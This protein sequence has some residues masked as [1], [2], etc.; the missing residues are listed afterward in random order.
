VSALWD[1]IFGAAGVSAVTDDQS[2]L[3]ALCDAEA[4]L[5]RSCAANG[6]LEPA[7]A[8]VV[9]EAC[10]LVA[11]DGTQD[12]GESSAADGNPVIPLVHRIKVHAQALG[13]TVACEG[14]HRGATSQD[15][16]DT[17]A[18]LVARAAL[19]VIGTAL[20]E[21]SGACTALVRSHRGTAM[22][23]RTLMQ[24]ALPTTFGALAAGW[25]DGLDL[26][27]T[28]LSAERS[29]L[30]VQLGGATGTLAAWHPHGPAVRASMAADLGLIDP[31][32]VWHTERSR[33]ADL[34]TALGIT[35]GT[36]GKIATDVVLLAQD[37]V[38]EVREGRGG[39]SSAMPHKHNPIAAI[40]AR[41]AAAQAPG[42]VGTLLAS[43]VG[44][45]QRGAGA[46]HAEWQPLV[47]LLRATGG[48]ACRVAESLSGLQVLPEAMSRNLRLIDTTAQPAVGATEIADTYL[49]RHP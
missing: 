19:E 39:G 36:L 32:T 46:W 45:L 14:V 10:A 34:A 16:L 9:V 22:P 8:A 2:W 30:A 24:Q 5:A 27:V 41:A 18:M 31:G 7:D 17:A 33:I 37:E 20:V 4:A 44:E 43:M 13:G 40:T 35:C 15:I 42:L 6:L 1:P 38:G 21:A 25:G 49:E 29:S 48:A 3:Q 26:A 23:G 11:A 28:R 47:A 12:L